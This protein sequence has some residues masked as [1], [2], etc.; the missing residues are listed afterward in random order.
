VR[1]SSACPAGL[2]LES[3][4]EPGLFDSDAGGLA[5]ELVGEGVDTSLLSSMPEKAWSRRCER[6][7]DP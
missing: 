5:L 1:P 3:D 4:D 2:F 6:D 7:G